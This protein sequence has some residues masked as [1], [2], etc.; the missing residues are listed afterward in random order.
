VSCTGYVCLVCG[1]KKKS[2]ALS[3]YFDRAS[4]CPRERTGSKA[5]PPGPQTIFGRGGG[6]LYP[7]IKTDAIGRCGSKNELTSGLGP[8]LMLMTQTG[9]KIRL[10]ETD[11]TVKQL[12][13]A[14]QIRS[15]ISPVDVR[16]G[17]ASSMC[18]ARGSERLQA[19]SLKA[20]NTLDGHFKYRGSLHRLR[21]APGETSRPCHSGSLST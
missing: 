7:C 3:F 9:P 6:Q 2:G 13:F 8:G 11:E 18:S 19:P 5:Y 20:E 14:R 21:P 16:Y 1:N 17:F 12:S 15:C 4:L 10:S